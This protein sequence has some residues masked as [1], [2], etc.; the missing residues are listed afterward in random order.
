MKL[1]IYKLFLAM[2]LLACVTE[3]ACAKDAAGGRVVVHAQGGDVPVTVEVARTPERR[4][5]GLMYRKQLASDAGMLF[6][7]DA[8]E[9]LTFWMKNTV[10]P[11]DMIFIGVD[12]KIVGIVADAKPFTTNPLGVDEPSLYVLEVNAGF[13]AKHG[14]AVGDEVGF[15]RLPSAVAE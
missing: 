9:H 6:V 12:H 4:A 10:L 7:F 2:A 15:L 3:S 11:L 5:L 1:R 8:P 14:L 13:A